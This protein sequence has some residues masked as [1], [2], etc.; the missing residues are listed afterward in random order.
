M[1]KPF[2]HLHNHSDYSL[3]D[4]AAKTKN[5]VHQ[6]LQF[7]MPALALTDHGN[8]FGAIEF[9]T[10]AREA[11]IKP[12]IGI[13]AYITP[14]SRHDRKPPSRGSVANHITL[15]AE[16][17]TGYKN[18]IKLTSAAYLEGF[19]YKPR[20]DFEL[21]ESL[22]EGLIALSGC[23]K[24]LIADAIYRDQPDRAREMAG[25]LTEVFGKGN[26]YMEIM[27]HGLDIERKQMPE[28]I[29]LSRE[30]D[31]PLVATN[32]T[33][34]LCRD[35]A[36]AQDAMVCIQTGKTI[37]DDKRLKF[38]TNEL[39]LKSPAEMYELFADH[40]DALRRTLE[41]AERCNL[42]FKFGDNYLPNFP[43]PAGYS[44]MDLLREKA[45]EGA[46]LRF[47]NV[48]ER[49]ENR[50]EKE[51]KII[52]NTGFPG[53]F[54]IVADLVN[55]AKDMGI[56]VGPGRGSAAGSLVSY[57]L[58]VTN[59]DPLQ[60][61]L[62]FERFLNPERVSMPDIDIDFSDRER[63]RIIRYIREKY[64]DDSVCQIITFGTMAAHAVVRDVGRVMG[65]SFD[66]VDRIAKMI[67]EELKI[68]LEDALRRRPDL[69]K[70]ADNDKKIGKLIEISLV[71]EGLCRHASTHAAGV[72]IAPG[73][74]TDYLPL[75]RSPRKDEIT[76]QFDM[77][78][79]E[80]I[81][82]LK[83]D[84]LGLRT[85]TVIQDALEMIERHTG[86]KIDL[87]A[88]PLDD[89]DALEV[90]AGGETVGIFQFES[91]G[92]REY[93]RKLRPETIGDIVAMNALYRPG[94][95]EMIDDFIDRKHGRIEVR[96]QHPILEPILKE[97]YGVMVYQE[98]VMQIASE[99]GGFSLGGAD[100][101]RRAMGKKK[102]EVM[103]Q[104]KE[105]FLDG[106]R[107]KGIDSKVAETVFDQMAKFA[108]YGFNKS[109]SVGYG[110]LAYQ[111]A[112]LKAHYP[113]EFMAATLT[114]VMTNS[115]RVAIFL[116]ECR[117]MKIPILPP[118][119]NSSGVGFTVVDEGIRFGLA[120]VKNVGVG[121]V[122]A[123]IEARAEGPF[124]S[125]GDFLDRVD[126]KATNKRLV[127]SLI[128]AGAC[129]TLP[130]QPEQQLAVLEPTLEL[131]S[132][133]EAERASGQM[134]LFGVAED[135]LPAGD[136]RFPE[137]PAS[138][139]Q[140]GP[141]V[142]LEFE[143]EYL[144]FYISGHPLDR[145]AEELD[146]FT[147]AS[148]ADFE[149]RQAECGGQLFLGGL[150]STRRIFF[151]RRGR[152]SCVIT[153]EDRLGSVDIFVFNEVFARH[154]EIVEPGSSVLVSGKFSRRERDERGKVIADWVMSLD[155]VRD[156]SGVGVELKIE[157]ERT[158]EAELKSLQEILLRHGGDN[159]VFLR[160]VEPN[161]SYL[162]KSRELRAAP[163]DELLAELRKLLG[164]RKV[165]L[166]YHPRHARHDQPNGG[167]N[168]YGV[169]GLMATDKANGGNGG[170][171]RGYGQ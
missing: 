99:M 60:Y 4:G 110:I 87:D 107:K 36:E 128:H 70:L 163:T 156:D 109:H 112:W 48:D 161:G 114:S 160:V 10:T 98:Q 20:I 33:H 16:N 26:F 14:A 136:E 125:L 65:M 35:H 83:I 101:L 92:M 118:D 1:N 106:A 78:G 111:T 108:G 7:G 55:A 6:A 122:E 85:L 138:Y 67:P 140:W 124:T 37:E 147:S 2:V 29:K 132:K 143:K 168:G 167:G 81:G 157:A 127:E 72:V 91:S 56:P 79:V 47:H 25:R 77:G 50:L 19:Y 159:P 95:M 104:Q 68:T 84:I 31:I 74:L 59:I 103:E 80:K 144:G 32:D 17:E 150:I 120:A 63:D 46:K 153:L 69:K 88:I 113:R 146:A 9:Y 137:L 86:E 75:F 149:E 164:E 129:R 51:L 66:E 43:L 89:R 57:C 97:T 15:L 142:Y 93:L 134:G 117:R 76:T 11:G 115:D 119:V 152:E 139:E 145:Y 30:L 41:I 162:L 22:R 116:E 23:P 52:E 53:Y 8:L 155:R 100:M 121:A 73:N 171:R 151:D 105:K 158:G 166:G 27:D 102:A 165:A 96:Y 61:N 154:R 64:G 40:E 13:E 123:I 45:F 34:Y 90:F 5:L 62:L 71:L 82:L 18:L 58:R 38:S 21:L 28:L 169:R 135:A 170:V 44:E 131:V 94:P 3:L 148:S 54:L 12:I 39:Y 49:I 130:G 126:K 42:E 24:G 133:M 141:G